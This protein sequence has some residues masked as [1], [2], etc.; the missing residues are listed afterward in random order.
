MLKQGFKEDVEQV[1]IENIIFY[2]FWALLSVKLTSIS[3]RSASSRQQ[4]LTGSGRWQTSSSSG[5]MFS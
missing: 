3:Y 5:T 1:R 2:R 4:S